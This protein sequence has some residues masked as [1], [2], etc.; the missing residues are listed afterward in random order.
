MSPLAV[1]VVPVSRLQY[2]ARAEASPFSCA[3]SVIDCGLSLISPGC[4]A[5]VY[6]N[7]KQ[8][9]TT[10]TFMICIRCSLLSQPLTLAANATISMQM[11]EKILSVHLFCSLRSADT[12]ACA[13][14]I[15]VSQRS[16]SS[17]A[18]IMGSPDHTRGF[19]SGLPAVIFTWFSAPTCSVCTES[20]PVSLDSF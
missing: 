11:P 15:S 10:T 17:S 1:L 13:S 14:N 3:S 5:L 20:A 7:S 12:S 6:A 18:F 2:G 8:S 16:S 4:M 19:F 9:I